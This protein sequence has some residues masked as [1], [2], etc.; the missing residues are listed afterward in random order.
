MNLSVFLN[1]SI[2]ELN[3][4]FSVRTF[5]SIQ[6]LGL[7]RGPDEVGFRDFRN[8][9]LLTRKAASRFPEEGSRINCRKD[10]H[11]ADAFS[12]GESVE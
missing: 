1:V 10:S 3:E 5:D 7:S 2:L 11:F 8:A 4:H 6:F 12:G 9:S